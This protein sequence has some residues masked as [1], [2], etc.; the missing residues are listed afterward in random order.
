MTEGQ[1]EH[2]R[3]SSSPGKQQNAHSTVKDLEFWE[4]SIEKATKMN[5]PSESVR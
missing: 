4:E 1:I 3:E 5:K 2:T